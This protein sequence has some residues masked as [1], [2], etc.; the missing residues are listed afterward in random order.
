MERPVEKVIVAVHGIGDQTR[1]STIQQVLSQFSLYHGQTA[2]VPL[3]NFHTKDE[4]A[5]YTSNDPEFHGLGFAEVYWAHIPRRIA[6]EKYLL[7]DVQP[8]VRTVI[9]RVHRHRMAT[10]DLTESDE[11][12]IEQVL[13][14]M[15][16]TIGVLDRLCFLADK[17]GIF[18][19]D[20]KKVLVDFVDDVQ[21]VAEFKRE[22]GEI[23]QVF[24]ER[25]QAVHEQFQD[26][27]EIYIVAHSEGTVVTLLG[28]LSALCTQG[29]P[30]I[31]KVH[32]LMT[33]GSPID[34][35]LILWPELFEE[36]VEPCNR[37]PKPIVWHNYY[38]YG[39]PVGFELETARNRFTTGAWQGVFNFPP[40]NDHGF[41]RYP[42]PGKAHTDYWQDADVF[43][44]F[45]QN[46]VEKDLPEARMEPPK[47]AAER[48]KKPP[49]SKTLPRIISWVLPYMLG[50]ALLF[51]AVLFLYNA[52]HGFLEPDQKQPLLQV[53]GNVAAIS[54]LLAGITVMARIPRLTKVWT[55]RLFGGLVF[56]L[57]IGGYHVFRRLT[58]GR[59][60]FWSR[61]MTIEGPGLFVGVAVVLAIAI[62]VASTL[63]P[64]LGMRALLIPGALA[65]AYV[66][67]YYIEGAHGKLWP[68]FVAGAVFLYLWWLAALLFDLT[69]VWHRYIRMSV[70]IFREQSQAQG[71]VP[72]AGQGRL[73]DEFASRP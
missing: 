44:H 50:A 26:A 2:A 49:A 35:H 65:V 62:T 43:G 71:A 47:P 61:V 11:R 45:I 39:D 64:K 5:V 22:G 58:E 27:E 1:F 19:F 30:W 24:A 37:P 9:G 17:M 53:F 31:S 51:I 46:V 23:G 25:M 42:L 28:L 63:F 33:F 55:W 34:K 18:S 54:C 66:V 68:I 29:N 57:S 70:P 12:M 59:S 60:G 14:E 32:G 56:L 10:R 7:E 52:V 3:G 6:E 72:G 48:Y 8:W 40:E 38:D 4:S 15:L 67:Y 16:Q 73:R 20:L 13:G 36:F 41:A 69:F 21:I